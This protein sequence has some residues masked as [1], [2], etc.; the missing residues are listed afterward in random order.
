MRDPMVHR[1]QWPL[2]IVTRVFPSQNDGKVRT[3]EVRIIRDGK[4]VTF[5]RPIT[6]LVL[7]ID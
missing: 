2:G 5:V 1:G 6:E 4:R 7:L 3:V